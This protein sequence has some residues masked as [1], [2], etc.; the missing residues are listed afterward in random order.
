MFSSL[1]KNVGAS[2]NPLWLAAETL[3]DSLL[4]R[5]E[6]GERTKVLLGSDLVFISKD[7][8]GEGSVSLF[9]LGYSLFWKHL[10]EI[11]SK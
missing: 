10:G 7:L 5:L 2:C 11:I 1:E 4:S 6:F 9:P 8:Q 3:R